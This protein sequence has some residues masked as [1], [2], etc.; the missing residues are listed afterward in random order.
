MTWISTSASFAAR[1]PLMHHTPQPYVVAQTCNTNKCLLPDCR[2]GGSDVLGGLSPKD[3][4]Q[5]ILVTFDD[6]INYLNFDIYKEKWEVNMVMWDH[7]RGCECSMV[8]AYASPSDEEFIEFLSKNFY[9]RYD[10]NKAPFSPLY[11]SAW[12]NTPHRREGLIK[13]LNKIDSKDDV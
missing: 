2:C 6:G 1:P 4:P 10:S 13:F 8:D 9:R 3:I 11:Y 5:I 7:L 12:F